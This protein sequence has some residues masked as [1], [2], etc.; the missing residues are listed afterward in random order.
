MHDFLRQI[1]PV[2]MDIW[3][4]FFMLPYALVFIWQLWLCLKS[5]SLYKK[6]VPAIIT[7]VIGVFILIYRFVFIPLGIYFLGFIALFLIGTALFMLGGIV[8]GWIIY[9]LY[10]F[11]RKDHKNG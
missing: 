8:S 6:F 11:L 1:I 2:S 3:A 4:L 7:V 5:E 10:S 9:G